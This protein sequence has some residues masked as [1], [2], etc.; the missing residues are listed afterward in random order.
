M[1]RV[2]RREEIEGKKKKKQKKKKNEEEEEEDEPQS[3]RVEDLPHTKSGGLRAN[4]MLSLGSW[5]QSTLRAARARTHTPLYIHR[6]TLSSN[7]H[8]YVDYL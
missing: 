6:R 3:K 5:G 8:T 2:E 4:W 1:K 7:S